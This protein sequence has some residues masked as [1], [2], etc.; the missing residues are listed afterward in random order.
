MRI[1]YIALLAVASLPV[2]ACSGRGHAEDSTPGIPGS[3]SGTSRTFQAADFT[4]VELRGS[5]DVDVRT[6]AA[7]SVRAEGPSAELDKLKIVRI[8]DTLRIGRINHDGLSWD[9]FGHHDGQHVKI[10]VTLPRLAEASIAGSGDM[11]VDKVEGAKFAG[12]SA[13]SGNLVVGALAVDTADLSIAGSGDMTVKGSARQ[14]GIDIAGSGSVD[15]SGLKAQGARVSIAGSG[16]ARA[17][18]TGPA[19]VSV[20]GSGDVDL[21]SGAKCTTSKMGSGDVHC[22]G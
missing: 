10:Y 12:S 14:L 11:T 13:G 22:G 16:D 15:G 21:G 9:D 7:F 5:D 18:V 4:G 17:D 6:G 20:M 2:A 1:R 3:G 8:G 19:T